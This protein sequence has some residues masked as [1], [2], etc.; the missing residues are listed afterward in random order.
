MTEWKTIESA[1][2]TG[3]ILGII[4]Y[5]PGRFGE[6]FIC[7]YDSEDGWECEFRT[8]CRPHVP[9]HWTPLPPAPQEE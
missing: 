9:T 2:K 1:P 3:K 6:P 5:A 7:V 8:E 4:E